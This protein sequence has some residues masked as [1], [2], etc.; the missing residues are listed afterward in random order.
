MIT[1]MYIAQYVD[2][3]KPIDGTLKTRHFA[4]RGEAERFVERLDTFAPNAYDVK[5]IKQETEI[6]RTRVQ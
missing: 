5:I 1:T 4:S 3:D 2:P 6:T